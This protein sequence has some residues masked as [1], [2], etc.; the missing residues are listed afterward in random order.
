[1][2]TYTWNI[3]EISAYPEYYNLNNVI[4]NT[5]WRLDGSDGDHSGYSLG[6]Q[7]LDISNIGLSFTPYSDLTKEQV[8]GWIVDAMGEETINT[9]KSNIELQ[10]QDQ[11]NPL[12]VKPQ[13]PWE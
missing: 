2:I 6:V 12:V 3:L 5:V 1:M 13:L 9:L 4:F 11:K 10:I 8:L 7:P